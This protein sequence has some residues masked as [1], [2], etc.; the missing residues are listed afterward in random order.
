V[1]LKELAD[2][3]YAEQPEKTLYHYTSLNG[4]LGI[5]GSRSLLMTDVR[6]LND[7]VAIQHEVELFS[8]NLSRAPLAPY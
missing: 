3:M 8:T 1:S 2:E 7:A 4:L 5:V 6:Y